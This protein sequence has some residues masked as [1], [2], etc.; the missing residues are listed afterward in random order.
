L[1]RRPGIQAQRPKLVIDPIE[2]NLKSDTMMTSGLRLAQ[3]M[4]RGLFALLPFAS[5]VSGQDTAKRIGAIEFFG[6]SGVDLNKIRASLPIREG[7]SFP[8]TEGKVFETIRRIREEVKK[9]SGNPPTDIAVVCCDTQGNYMIFIGLAGNTTVNAS[10]N[11]V[12]TGTIRLPPA[13]VSLYRE[14]MDLSSSLV[15]QGRAIEDR[16]NGYALSTDE[17][18]RKKQ[19]EVRTFA[20]EH[21]QL[22]SQVLH[23]SADPEQRTV[24]AHF[25]GYA[26]QSRSQ[27]TDLLWASRDAHDGVRNNAIRAL[28]VLAES[29]S[30]ITGQIPPEP[31]IKMLKSGVWTD[32]NKGGYVLEQISKSR[33]PKLLRLLRAEA[34]EALIEMAH[35]RSGGHAAGARTIL[36]RIAGIEERRLNQMIA[37]GEIEQIIDAVKKK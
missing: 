12:P 34:L 32:R 27:I 33:S 24:A 10:Y 3:Y 8:A 6:Y 31:F 23:S 1:S 21:Q 36:G 13:A 18:L 16:S 19:L 4:T 26:R 28:G 25:M 35:W 29:N 9:S 2:Q 15:S 37:A 14:L 30:Q 5:I 22:L 11:A 17:S 20:M 7:D